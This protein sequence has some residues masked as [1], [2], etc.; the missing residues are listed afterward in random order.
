MNFKIA[1][2]FF[3]VFYYLTGHAQT[4]DQTSLLDTSLAKKITVS[5]FCLCQTTLPDL[6]RLSNDFKPIEVEEMDLGKK[7]TAQDS[8][9]ENGKGYFSAKFPGMIFQKD[10]STD[11]ISKI[12]LTKDF[13][14]NLP[15]GTPIDMHNLRLKD[16]F[17]I[18]PKLKDTW[19]SRGCSDYWHFANDTL[20]FY[21]RVDT[22]KKP[23]FPIDE[24]YYYDKPI[25]AIDLMVSCYR[26]FEK[27]ERYKQL[28]NDPIFFI[29]SVNVTRIEM[30]EY[31]PNDI[32]AVTVYKDANAI[33]LVGEQGKFGVVYIETKRFARNKYWNY[34]KSKSADYLKNVPTPQSDS[35][36]IYILNGK[37]L[38]TNFEG[39]L[40]GIDDK[41]FIKLTVI[42]KQKLS[43]DYNISDKS[44]GVII[45]TKPKDDKD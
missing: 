27:N 1:F 9:F 13:K 6:Q 36:V 7:C 29:D 8:R 40:S 18:Y 4:N 32:A 31:Q 16:V 34:F 17:N 35:S 38:K 28:L 25:E 43:K 42:D 5:G 33:K 20:F 21:V 11:Q 44:F 19:G 15:D 3:L 45:K 26:I 14:G 39:D 41:N 24:A 2:S 12:R 23:Q 30:Q 10:Q 22:T 37:V